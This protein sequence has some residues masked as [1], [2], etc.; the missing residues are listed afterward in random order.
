MSGDEARD[1]FL[2]ELRTRFRAGEPVDFV[3]DI[4]ADAELEQVVIAHFDVS[5]QAG[6]ADSFRYDLV[7]REYVEPPEPP[8][9]GLDTPSVDDLAV[10]IGLDV[11]LGLDLLD[12]PGLIGSVPEIGPLLEP[13]KAAADELAKALGGAGQLFK[14]LSDLLES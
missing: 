12:L 9:L 14:P 2:T 11:D 8:G 7:L 4:V 1:G 13:V 10:D 3:A 6:D 5:E